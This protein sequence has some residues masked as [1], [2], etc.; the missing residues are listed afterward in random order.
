M[1]L[2]GLVADFAQVLRIV[3]RMRWAISGRESIFWIL[4]TNEFCGK[5]KSCSQ[6]RVTGFTLKAGR[7][8]YEKEV[9]KEAEEGEKP[10]SVE[11][12]GESRP[13]QLTSV[14]D[15]E[16]LLLLIVPCLTSARCVALW[17]TLQASASAAGSS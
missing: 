8:T 4:H 9:P 5:I 16:L 3:C 10:E 1:T 17:T 14:A 7:R 2:L 11:Y 12:G 15:G 6:A 13:K